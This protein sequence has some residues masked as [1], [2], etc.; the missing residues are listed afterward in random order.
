MGITKKQQLG[1]SK[2]HGS[3]YWIPKLWKVFSEYIRLKED[4]CY[5][6]GSFNNP[7]AGHYIDKSVTRL[8]L[9]FDER[10]VHRQC[11]AC[12][13]YKSGNKTAYATRLER[14]YGYGIL[15]QLEEEK[16]KVTKWTDEDF[17]KRYDFYK[18][19]LSTISNLF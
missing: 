3:K 2:K 7:Q 6:C 8:S 12:N 17:Q 4:R 13:M 16:T 1:K 11:V 10:N 18:D 19:R 14:D 15:Q 9:Y 5:T